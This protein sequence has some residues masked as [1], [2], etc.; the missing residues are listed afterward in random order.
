V[1]A[2]VRAVR[3]GALKCVLVAVDFSL[4]AERT[5][6]SVGLLPFAA[7][8]EVHLVHALET[9]E[10]KP[11][12]L[13]E[14]EA[15]AL[16]ELQ[17][18]AG[19]LERAVAREGRSP[20]QVKVTVL[21][22]APEERLPEEAL[23]VGA[24]LIVVGRHGRRRFG[25][26]LI[27]ATAERIV[28]NS[29]LPVLVVQRKKAAA[30]Q[31]P[32]VAVD[33]EEESPSPLHR[34]Q[35]FCPE[36]PRMDVVH[37][38]DTSNDLILQEAGASAGQYREYGEALRKEAEAALTKALASAPLSPSVAV[39]PLVHAGDPRSVILA[40]ARACRSDL[41]VLGTHARRGLA[42]FFMGS[43]AESVLRHAPCD[44][45]LLPSPQ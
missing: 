22:G 21:K 32:L 16:R 3:Q 38:Y 39:K 41:L 7:G 28:R 17:Q 11:E 24:E 4:Y 15:L 18:R 26:S 29:R 8:A 42:H 2:P 9:K 33:L 40:E 5:V 19:S 14:L 45:L 30:W 34:L 27:G 36:A 35:R 25:D 13:A 31:Q 43:V 37:V 6:V 23:R 20:I 1:Q 44:V 12:A 10:R